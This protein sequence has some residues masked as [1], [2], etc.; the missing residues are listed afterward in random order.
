[1]KKILFFILTGGIIMSANAQPG[2]KFPYE[3]MEKTAIAY[4]EAYSNLDA[5]GMGAQYA[6]DVQYIDETYAGYSGKPFNATGR[7]VVVKTFKE[8]FFPLALKYE[9]NE[10]SHFFSGNQ[11]VFQGTLVVHYK[12]SVN[13]KSDD[14][15]YLWS[16]PYVTILTFKDGKI[17]QQN[18]YINYPGGTFAEK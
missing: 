7:D 2:T 11:G 15:T 16:V 5:E 17:I 1:M 3:E 6:E 8:N 18:D 4:F 10:S 13:G 14:I 9:W 12:G